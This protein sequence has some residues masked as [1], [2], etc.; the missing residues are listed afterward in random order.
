MPSVHEQ[1]TEQFYKWEA[2]GRGW[3]VFEEPVYPEPP[4]VPFTFRAMKETPAVDDG[5][6]TTFLSRFARTLARKPVVEVTPEPEA[7]VVKEEDS[8][9]TQPGPNMFMFK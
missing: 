1:L 5:R 3:Q 7:A 8:P 4:F 9:T 6:E 2:R